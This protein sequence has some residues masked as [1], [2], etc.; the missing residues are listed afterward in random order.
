MY[1]EQLEKLIEMALLDGVITEKERKVLL[2][3]AQEMGVDLDEFEMVLEA[4]LYKVKESK[5]KKEPI[6]KCPNCGDIIS[7]LTQICASCD[8]ILQ[9]STIDSD[10]VSNLH[11]T[12]QKIENLII[13]IKTCP[14]PSFVSRLKLIFLT[15]I[16]F[17]LYLVYRRIFKEKSLDNLIAKCDKEKRQIQIYYGDDKKVKLLIEELDLEIKDTKEHH[18]K[19]RAKANIGCFT[20]VAILV[21]FFIGIIIMGIILDGRAN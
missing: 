6:N 4:R 15:Y 3:K 16:T 13:D 1:D 18:H 14:K 21:L 7:G 8:Y 11:E 12:I 2:K 20:I 5:Q 10:N 19:M 9:K 17:G